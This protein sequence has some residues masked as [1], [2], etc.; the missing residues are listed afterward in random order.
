MLHL[1]TAK[2]RFGLLNEGDGA[3]Q[4]AEA[5]E[6][7]ARGV[8][9]RAQTEQVAEREA[10]EHRVQRVRRA[11]EQQPVAV[12]HVRSA[13]L[14]HPTSATSTTS[15]SSTAASARSQRTTCEPRTRH[16]RCALRQVKLRTRALNHKRTPQRVLQLPV[17]ARLT[18]RNRRLTRRRHHVD[19][20]LVFGSLLL[21]T[22]TC[23]VRPYLLTIKVFN[24]NIIIKY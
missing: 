1:S 5:L 18:I 21:H 22:R 6:R 20:Q 2:E 13:R 3:E 17:E 12:R 19:G 9:G 7:G 8:V 16:T 10:V 4:R 11:P 23:T 15:A 24:I 14:A